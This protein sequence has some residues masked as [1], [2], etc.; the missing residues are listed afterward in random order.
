MHPE[1]GKPALL[2]GHFVKKF[3]GLGPVESAALFQLFQARMTKLENTVR[4]N[5][6]LGDMAIWDNRATQ[7]Y[8]ISDYDDQFRRLSRVTLTGEIP[9]DV[10]GQSSRVVAGDASHCSAVEAPVVLAG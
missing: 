6:R 8:A 3:V 9:V 4:W 7:H 2:L 1:T 5:W 10:Y